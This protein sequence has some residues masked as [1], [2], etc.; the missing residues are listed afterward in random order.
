MNQ[1]TASGAS[2]ASSE[3]SKRLAFSAVAIPV[4]VWIVWSGGI[5]LALFLAGVSALAAWEF[6]KLAIGSGSEPL[7][8]HGVVFSALIPLFVHARIVGWWVP[9][10]STACKPRRGCFAS[11]FRGCWWFTRISSRFS[12]GCENWWKRARAA[13]KSSPPSTGKMLPSRPPECQ[14]NAG[15]KERMPPRRCPP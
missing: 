15:Y 11:P 12:A 14:A 7:W 9:P 3:L 10:L 8:G 6:Y 5:A 1:P 2:S 13:R 4:V